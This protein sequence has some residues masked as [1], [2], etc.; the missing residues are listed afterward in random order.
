MLPTL[1]IIG[2]EHHRVADAA[3]LFGEFF[4][5]RSA[6]I[7]PL[8]QADVLQTDVLQPAGYFLLPTVVTT[9]NQEDGTRSIRHQC[10][11]QYAI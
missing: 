9:V 5:N 10:S 6:G 2:R 3:R 7:W 1:V 11:L 4:N 8:V